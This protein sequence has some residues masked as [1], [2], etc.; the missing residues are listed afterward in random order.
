MC[1]PRGHISL[2]SLCIC[3][4]LMDMKGFRGETIFEHLSDYEKND[5]HFNKNLDNKMNI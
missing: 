4:L 2:M 1:R 3:C 5:D